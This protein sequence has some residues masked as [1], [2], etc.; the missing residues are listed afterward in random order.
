M[1]DFGCVTSRIHWIKFKFSRAK[2]CVIV[3]YGPNEDVKKER[4]LNDM[5]RNLDSIG[6]G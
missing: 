3:G 4:F 1:L 6:N 2:V 5:D